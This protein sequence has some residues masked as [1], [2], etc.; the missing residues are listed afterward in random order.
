M[1]LR[2][3]ALLSASLVRSMP[4]MA[5]PVPYDT[6]SNAQIFLLGGGSTLLNYVAVQGNSQFSTSGSQ[7]G[8][9]YSGYAAA[10]RGTLHSSSQFNLVG[11]I[12]AD[13]GIAMQA[14]W[15][16]YGVH[17]DTV[18][19]PDILAGIS[20]YEVT[21]NLDGTVNGDFS[22]SIFAE[23][24]AY[25][26]QNGTTTVTSSTFYT[27]PLGPVTFYLLPQ[28]PTQNFDFIFEL[29]TQAITGPGGPTSGSVDFRNTATFESLQAVDANHN[30]I[31][32]VELE[33]SDGT[34]LG[35]DGITPASTSVTPE[36]STLVLLGTGVLSLVG[37]A[38]R[39]FL[40]A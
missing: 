22:A 24:L 12:P 30:V 37:A 36:P 26:N 39:K 14:D 8:L 20:A 5:D 13:A 7:A 18:D 1:H 35:P 10:E 32:G 38:R 27:S 19:P 25:V 15:Y 29:Y 11:T 31:P 2:F 17:V 21:F 4:L 28:D 34:L 6:S 40:N 16:E 33:L 23:L 3:L 9:S